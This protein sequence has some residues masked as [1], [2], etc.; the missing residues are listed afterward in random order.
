MSLLFYFFVSTFLNAC[1]NHNHQGIFADT[2]SI[3]EA[4][5]YK[6]AE[7]FK[8]SEFNNGDFF[9]YVFNVFVGADST[10]FV[11]D[12]S[13]RKIHLFN[14]DGT[15]KDYLGGYGA[16]PGE[17]RR[18][19]NM[20]LL[21]SDTLLV[22]DISLARL[23]FYSLKKNKW[24]L[25]KTVDYPQSPDVSL[26]PGVFGFRNFYRI[27][28]GYVGVYEST[29]SS[30][31]SDT[32]NFIRVCFVIYNDNLQ[33]ITTVEPICYDKLELIVYQNS[34]SSVETVSAMPIPEG[35]QT[36]FTVTDKG[37]IITTWTEYNS[38]SIQPFY[39]TESDEFEYYSA[40]IPITAKIEEDLVKKAIP[41]KNQSF[42]SENDLIGKIP[43]YKGYAEQMLLDDEDQIWI[44]TRSVKDNLE[45]FIY[46]FNGN[47][48]GR[49]L[50]SGGQFTQIKKN[51]I[52]VVNNSEKEPSFSVY[53]IQK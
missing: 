39:S 27:K 50:H 42:F 17:F 51:K 49:V 5:L 45:W 21:S 47:L 22:V 32:D 38:I 53:E 23:T 10:I 6:I 44:L 25:E 34:G 33:P 48:N 18:I 3:N 37:D 15:Y 8:V 19:S 29:I 1:T 35:Y 20:S 36:L 46:D 4:P 40:M 16:G 28:N 9:G 24:I 26:E 13:T 41:N 11:S 52:Y 7:E 2:S 30:F 14:Y 12:P 43:S 31:K